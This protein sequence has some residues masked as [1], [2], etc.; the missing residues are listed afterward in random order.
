L[1]CSAIEGEGEVVGGGGGEED[2][3]DDDSSFCI[4]FS[5][6]VHILSKR[7]LQNIF[8]IHFSS[9]SD[10]VTCVFF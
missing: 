1:D 5:S 6:F 8:C 9:V 2:N 10:D 4:C 7:Y 3:D